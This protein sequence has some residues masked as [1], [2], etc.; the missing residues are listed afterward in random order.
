MINIAK[1]IQSKGD[2]DYAFVLPDKDTWTVD[3]CL[4]NIYG[5]SLQDYT[6]QDIYDAVGAAKRPSLTIR[7]WWMPLTKLLNCANTPTATPCPWAMTQ[8]FPNLLPV[9]ATCSRRLLGI[10][11]SEVC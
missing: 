2:G 6:I 11:F 10:C 4:S 1:D 9:L 7:N 5:K 8:L 3:Q